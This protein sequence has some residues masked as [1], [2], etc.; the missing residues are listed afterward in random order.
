MGGFCQRLIT[1]V[2]FTHKR[3]RQRVRKQRERGRHTRTP[4]KM[5]S[6]APLHIFPI[7]VAACVIHELRNAYGKWQITESIVQISIS[8]NNPS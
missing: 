1:A 2:C 6:N 3:D 7:K 4:N 5:H 8:T